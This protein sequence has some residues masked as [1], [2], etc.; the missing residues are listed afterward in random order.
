[1]PYEFNGTRFAALFLLL[2]VV[3]G[4]F[5]ALVIFPMPPGQACQQPASSVNWVG[6]PPSN[7]PQSTCNNVAGSNMQ[8]IEAS[9][10]PMMGAP[11]AQPIATLTNQ[12]GQQ[13]GYCLY[14]NPNYN[15]NY[16]QQAALT[17]QAWWVGL[18]PSIII[19]ALLSITITA[20]Y[21]IIVASRAHYEA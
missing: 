8:Y 10:Y 1:M 7:V 11:S 19:S 4:L 12:F 9:C 5:W 17:Y 15:P 18:L 13:Y 2:W 16:N 21:T 6:L 20:V 3:I 14:Q